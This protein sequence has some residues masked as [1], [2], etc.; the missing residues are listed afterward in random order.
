MRDIDIQDVQVLAGKR[1]DRNKAAARIEH[2]R[3][4][5]AQVPAK[6]SAVTVGAAPTQAQYNA[7]LEDVR[8]LYAGFNALRT[9]LDSAP[10][11]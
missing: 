4:L 7:L 11:R 3:A 8:D 6:P 1:G 10:V 2:L 9:L 5:V